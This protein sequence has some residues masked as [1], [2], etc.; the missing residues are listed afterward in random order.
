MSR[1]LVR[2]FLILGILSM[3]FSFGLVTVSAS[4]MS[5]LNDCF[6]RCETNY[7][8]CGIRIGG[9]LIPTAWCGIS[10]AR[11]NSACIDTYGGNQTPIVVTP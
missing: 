1:K 3:C 9:F 5:N 11:C 6:D 2:R 7:S 10:W 8:G 4:Q